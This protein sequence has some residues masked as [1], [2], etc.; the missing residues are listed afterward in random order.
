M[1]NFISVNVMRIIG[2][3]AYIIVFAILRLGLVR[4]ISMGIF[5]RV[6]TPGYLRDYGNCL[7]LSNLSIAIYLY[8]LFMLILME[9]KAN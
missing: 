8:Y 7:L 3:S 1:I 6:N 2:Q 4:L 9:F 5:L